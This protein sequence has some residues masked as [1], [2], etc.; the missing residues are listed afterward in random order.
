MRNVIMISMIVIMTVLLAACGN[1]AARQQGGGEQT[2]EVT[3]ADSGQ[4]GN[5]GA[6]DEQQVSG[7]A[8]FTEDTTVGEVISDP[9]F[10][11]Y[12]RLLFPVDRYVSEDMTLADISSSDIYV[13]YSNIDK[14]KTV[15]IVN[16]L[17]TRA[18]NGEQIFYNIYSDDEIE[19]DASRADTGLFFFKNN[20]YMSLFFF[21]YYNIISIIRLLYRIGTAAFLTFFFPDKDLF[22]QIFFR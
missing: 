19:E 2:T 1:S 5:T 9:A 16:D 4:S 7:T 12:G 18:E 11:D 10:G 14:N 20:Q 17:K 21:F 8:P 3:Q 6:S 13:W 15:E 22:L